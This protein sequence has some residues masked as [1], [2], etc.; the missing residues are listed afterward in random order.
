MHAPVPGGLTVTQDV[1][2]AW[3]MYPTAVGEHCCP[4]GEQV[5]VH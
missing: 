2:Q 4:E 5:H 3:S 1:A